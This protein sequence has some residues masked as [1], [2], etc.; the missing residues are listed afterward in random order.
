MKMMRN[1]TCP[2][3]C[4]PV[5]KKCLPCIDPKKQLTVL[6]EPDFPSNTNNWNK[7]IC[8]PCKG[9][10]TWISSPKALYNNRKLVKNPLP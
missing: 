2:A 10:Y 5:T 3:P 6:L 1:L 7:G 4:A 9:V 8:A